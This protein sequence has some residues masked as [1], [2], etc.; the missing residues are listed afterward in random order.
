MSKIPNITVLMP[1]YNAEEY[2]QE[3]IDSILRQTFTDYEFIIIDDG[4]TDNSLEIIKKYSDS[5]IRLVQNLKN[6]GLPTTLNIGMDLARGKYIARMDNDDIS[7]PLRF[8]KQVAFMDDNPHISICGTWMETIGNKKGK[9]IETPENNEEIKRSLLL[10]SSISHP[11]VFL[12][13]SEFNRCN[14]RYDPDYKDCEDIELWIRALKYLYASSL[15]QVLYYYRI[16]PKQ[17]CRIDNRQQKNNM[18][19]LMKANLKD[20]GIIPADKIDLYC[21]MVYLQEP[22]DWQS[23]NDIEELLIHIRALNNR[24]SYFGN[25]R[26]AKLLN[27]RWFAV[28]NSS[29]SNGMGIFFKYISSSIASYVYIIHNIPSVLKLFIKSLIRYNSFKA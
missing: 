24:Y 14:L 1:V 22:P 27:Y 29:T 13:M 23:V 18:T 12:R 2:L 10:D 20:S 4:S 8:E 7:H 17:T 26:F 16:H 3:A 25:D 28:C 5:R 21:S 6:L 11:T 15:Q 9:I 19:S